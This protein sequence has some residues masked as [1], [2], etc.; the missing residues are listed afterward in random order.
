MPRCLCG[1]LFFFANP[2]RASC[3]S[4]RPIDSL[5][6]ARSPPQSLRVAA[7]QIPV[8]SSPGAQCLMPNAW[9]LLRE[10]CSP[11]RAP[12]TV[13]R[14]QKMNPKATKTTRDF[15]NSTP[16]LRKT[17]QNSSKQSTQN[18]PG[19]HVHAIGRTHAP[20]SNENPPSRPGIGSAHKPEVAFFPIQ[21][22]TFCFCALLRIAHRI[23]SG[24]SIM[25]TAVE[26][27]RH[28][29]GTFDI[30]DSGSGA[31]SAGCKRRLS[32]RFR[33]L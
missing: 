11:F 13:L 26:S 15:P 27:S 5:H 33:I 9:C 18:A 8:F 14:A 30:E 16:K 3:A 24:G 20:P 23:P 21:A 4:W 19:A 29:P 6:C 17:L 2:S 7:K 32:A 10:S 12:N 25:P 22:P 1:Q 28:R 31:P